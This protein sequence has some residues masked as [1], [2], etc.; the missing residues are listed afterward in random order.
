MAKSSHASIKSVHQPSYSNQW[1]SPANLHAHWDYAERALKR[2][3]QAKDSATKSY[4]LAILPDYCTVSHAWNN[5][6]LVFWIGLMQE[7]SRRHRKKHSS[8]RVIDGWRMC[9]GLRITKSIWASLQVLAVYLYAT[10]Y[11]S[12]YFI[13]TSSMVFWWAR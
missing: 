5:Q 13:I 1:F 2:D 12:S 8:A 6:P 10:R 4:G 3:E 11:S 7:M 9:I